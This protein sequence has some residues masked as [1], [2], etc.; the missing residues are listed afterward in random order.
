[1]ALWGSQ[2][3]L[4][5]PALPPQLTAGPLPAAPE[6]VRIFFLNSGSRMAAMILTRLEA[7]GQE[8]LFLA[9]HRQP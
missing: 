2:A 8:R 3:D 6:C 4:G 9:D 7:A 1:M 5:E